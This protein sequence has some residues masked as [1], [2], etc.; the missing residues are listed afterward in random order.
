MLVLHELLKEI[1]LV[2]AHPAFRR[3]LE[4]GN[5]ATQSSACYLS[6]LLGMVLTRQ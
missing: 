6:Q 4:F 3:K 2:I 5:P 1:A